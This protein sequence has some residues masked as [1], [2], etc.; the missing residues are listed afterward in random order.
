LELALLVKDSWKIFMTTDHP[1][2]GPFTSYPRI[3]A[4]LMS[5]KAR[6]A[7]LRRLNLRAQTK[8]L[9]PSINREM[10]FYEIAT[11][12]RAGQARALGLAQKGHLGV[13][14]DGDIAI[15]N[16]NPEKTDPSRKFK[17][18][19]KAFRSAAFTIKDGRVVVKNGEV[20][21]HVEGRTMWLDVQVSEQHGIRDDLKQNFKEYWT[22]EYENYAVG[23]DCLAA[24]LPMTV[25]AR[26]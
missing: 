9:L 25:R 23:E 19:R 18:V 11:V 5:R 16:I 15:Y 6:Q 7:A 24:S 12:T 22:V 13:G 4:W 17:T 8:S 2:G 21:K 1:N 20:L 10:S 26:V 3:I 14:A